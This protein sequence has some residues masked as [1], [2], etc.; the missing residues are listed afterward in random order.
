MDPK[1]IESNI[2]KLRQAQFIMKLVK[3][4]CDFNGLRGLR[5]LQVSSM[6]YEWVW[7]HTYLDDLIDLHNHNTALECL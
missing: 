7:D 1:V 5:G 2:N 3:P 4:L 6:V